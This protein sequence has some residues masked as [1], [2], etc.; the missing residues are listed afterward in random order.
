MADDKLQ[1]DSLVKAHLRNHE[2]LA[3]LR[4][5]W[6][7]VW[8]EIDERVNPLGGGGWNKTTQQVRGAGNFDVTAVES[9]DRFGAAMA[10]ITVPFQTQYIRPRFADKD[11]DKL[12]SV[13]RW[14]ERAGDRAG[15]L[16]ASQ[17]LRR[18]SKKLQELVVLEEHFQVFCPSARKAGGCA[19]SSRSQGLLEVSAVEFEGPGRV[20]VAHLG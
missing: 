4:A 13:R 17:H 1:D 9:L 18:V 2:R 5:P 16:G 12:P 10:A 3:M 15:R 19:A 7:S 14:C 6:E 11:L 20:V 8:Q